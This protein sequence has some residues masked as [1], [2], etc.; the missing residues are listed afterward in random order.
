MQSEGAP[1][2][3]LPIALLPSRSAGPGSEAPVLRPALEP[4]QPRAGAPRLRESGS[5]RHL[6]AIPGPG[7]GSSW[8]MIDDLGFDPQ[9]LAVLSLIASG[10]TL[11]GIV[12][13][14]RFMAERSIA[15]IVGALTVVGAILSAAIL[16]IIFSI[17]VIIFVTI[18]LSR[19]R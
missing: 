1:W 13:F 17:I 2:P 18:M 7:A 12:I 4:H 3:H 19:T 8:W 9:F 14:R 15:Y 5:P 10:L 11:F 16:G 6:R